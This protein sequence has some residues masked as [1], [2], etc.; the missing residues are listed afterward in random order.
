MII[1]KFVQAQIQK[2]YSVES[3]KVKL[4]SKVDEINE[5]ENYT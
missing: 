2:W 5:P 3:E 4:Q 1:L